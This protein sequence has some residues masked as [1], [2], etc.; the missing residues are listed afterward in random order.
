MSEAK[1]PVLKPE[2]LIKALERMGFF[3]ARKSNKVVYT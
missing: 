1:L 2:E 3:C